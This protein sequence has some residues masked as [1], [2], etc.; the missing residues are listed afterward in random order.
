MKEFIWNIHNSI[1]YY[2][3]DQPVDRVMAHL[4]DGCEIFWVLDDRTDYFV[5]NHIYPA[6]NGDLL[7]TRADELHHPLVTPNVTYR[8][9]FVQFQPQVFLEI[10]GGEQFLAPL[11]ARESGQHNHYAPSEKEAKI[12]GNIRQRLKSAQEREDGFGQILK[13]AALI[14]LLNVLGKLTKKETAPAMEG[15]IS[16]DL[17]PIIG[18]IR[19]HIT[20]ELSLDLI[21]QK[22]YIDK[23]TLCRKFKKELGITVLEYIRNKRIM[24]AREKLAQGASVKEA[25]A[26]SGFNDYAN[27]IRTFTKLTGFS[28]GRYGKMG[29]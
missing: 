16:T 21:A 26:V 20:S 18:Y 7:I 23:S 19:A 1:E 29:E 10:E 17:L 22:F 13:M 4:H 9:A 8:R 2:E 6:K 27:F 14:D 12:L 3:N 15:A 25:C 24:I 11:L 28:P 5:E